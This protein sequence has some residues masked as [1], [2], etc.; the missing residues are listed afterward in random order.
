MYIQL[1]FL[2]RRFAEQAKADPS[3]RKKQPYKAASKA[4]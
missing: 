4:T 3:L 1:D 2:V